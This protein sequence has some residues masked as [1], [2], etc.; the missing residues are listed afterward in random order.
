[1]KDRPVADY[2]SRDEFNNLVDSTYGYRQKAKDSA[3]DPTGTR[4]RALLLLMRWSGLSISDAVTLERERLNSN[5]EILVYRA[6]TGVPVFVKLPPDVA[7]A[8]REV[9]PGPKP[10]PKKAQ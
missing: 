3:P 4:L 2:F 5:D 9:P 7:K 10:N 1:M 8:L 6:K